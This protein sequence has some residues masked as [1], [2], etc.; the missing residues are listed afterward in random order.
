MGRLPKRG[1]ESIPGII[2]GS[3]ARRKRLRRDKVR[4]VLDAPR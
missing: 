1:L 3:A 4:E 2:A